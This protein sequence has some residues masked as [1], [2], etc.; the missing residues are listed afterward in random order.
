[1]ED[2][3][4]IQ[5]DIARD[6]I[7]DACT[8]KYIRVKFKKY[9]RILIA[10]IPYGKL[11]LHIGDDVLQAGN[12]RIVISKSGKDGIR[13]TIDID[14]N[15]YEKIIQFSNHEVESLEFGN[16]IRKIVHAVRLE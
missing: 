15:P 10:L 11:I 2:Q 14:G 12:T 6:V 1:M 3:R 7:K 13:L 16:H 5:Q 9:D 8:E 4:Q